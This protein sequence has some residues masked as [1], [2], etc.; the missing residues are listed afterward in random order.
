MS[1][2][3]DLIKEKKTRQLRVE[4][5]YTKESILSLL[6]SLQNQDIVN[7]EELTEVLTNSLVK[8]SSAKLELDS[9]MLNY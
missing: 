2:I 7:S 1:N 6:A 8:V 4:L 5:D 9:K 3:S